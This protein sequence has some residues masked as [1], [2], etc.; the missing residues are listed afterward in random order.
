[1]KFT[2]PCFVRVE[3]AEKRKELTEWLKAIGYHVC[4]CCLFDGW[5]TLR[6]GTINRI[7]TDYEV[8]GT[9]NSDEDT[10][11]DIEWFKAE[12]AMKERPDI[13]CG[14]NIE[15]FKALAAMNDENDREQWFT[16]TAD[17]FCLCSSDRWSDEWQKEN[18]EKYYCYWRKATAEEII[19]HFKRHR[20]NGHET[21][22]R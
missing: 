16:D 4:S 1:M 11:C 12:N 22:S 17:D 14:E 15:L 2:T 5:N 3:D 6:C 10:W 20:N 9:P 18:F 13:D 8:H 7:Q 21:D 19:G